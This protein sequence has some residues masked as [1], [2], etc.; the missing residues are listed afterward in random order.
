[1]TVTHRSLLTLPML[2]ACALVAL[3]AWDTSGL[4]MALAQ[5]SGSAAGFPLRNNWL[6]ETVLHEGMRKLS[7][8]AVV[9]LCVAIWWPVGPLRR[10][11]PARRIELVVSTLAAVLGIVVLKAMN[12][13]SCP[14]DLAD[15]GGAA[16]YVSHWASPPGGDGG[17]GHC[18]PAGHASSGF[19]F[20]GG[21][22]VFRQVSPALARTWLAGAL[23]AG[24]ALGIGQQLRGAHF[25]SHTL[26]TGWVCWVIAAGVDLGWT[27]AL[28]RSAEPALNPV[29]GDAV[30]VKKIA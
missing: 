27:A 5:L 8:A 21:Y 15:F 19:A 18:F 10:L 30:A 11:A 3:V 9:F 17:G 12:A 4:D 2:T 24:L 16:R 26:W 22:F 1:M 29:L 14:W 25:M 20:I 13:T 28:T 6:L 7:W 23:L